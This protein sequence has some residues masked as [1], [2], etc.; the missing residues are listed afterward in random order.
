MYELEHTIL[1]SYVG[2]R[3]FF[4]SAPRI[5]NSLPSSV[6]ASDTRHLQVPAEDRIFSLKDAHSK[7]NASWELMLLI[8]LTALLKSSQR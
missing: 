3:A 5:W 8:L 4:V 6:T 2:D 7:I 1:I